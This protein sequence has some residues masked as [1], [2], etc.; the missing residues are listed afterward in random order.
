[1][2]DPD[3]GTQPDDPGTRPA[4]LAD[5]EEFED[6]DSDSVATVRP[7]ATQ[8]VYR[9]DFGDSERSARSSGGSAP[10]NRPNT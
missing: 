6:F 9:P 1:M 7:M 10:P 4:G 3:T 2:A 5:L 8:A